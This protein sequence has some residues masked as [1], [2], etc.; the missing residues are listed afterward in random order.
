MEG[1]LRHVAA[2]P[3]VGRPRSAVSLSGLSDDVLALLGVPAAD[4]RGAYLAHRGE[5]R[6]KL[7]EGLSPVQLDRLTL[8]SVRFA[9]QRLTFDV[10]QVAERQSAVAQKLEICFVV[11]QDVRVHLVL[12]ANLGAQP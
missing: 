9:V 10:Q 4:S 1:G 8:T 3:T 6:M 7:A 11:L 2:R 12:V 5:P